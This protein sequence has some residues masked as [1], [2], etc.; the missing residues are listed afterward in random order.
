MSFQICNVDHPNSTENTCAFCVFEAPDN[1]TNLKIGLERFQDE[2]DSLPSKTW[3]Y[4]M[5]RIK[6][7]NLHYKE[8]QSE[9]SSAVTTSSCVTCMVHQVQYF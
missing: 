4:Y 9:F 7:N 6:N 2:V 1:A 3:R 8:R 5:C